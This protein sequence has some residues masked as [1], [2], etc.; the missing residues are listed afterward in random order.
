MRAARSIG[1]SL[2]LIFAGAALADTVTLTAVADNTL[3]ED[4][5]GALSNGSGQHVFA[6]T[7]ASHMIRRACVRFDVSSIPPGSTINSA[8]LTLHLS[9]SI[10]GDLPVNVHRATSAWGE[11]VSIAPGREGMGAPSEPGDA[12]WLHTFYS[13]AFWN[14][15]GGDFLPAV[16]ATRLVG[17]EEAFLDW[18]G[19]GLVADVQ[20]WVD[21][22]AANNGWVLLGEES[23]K[24]SAK[25]FDSRHNIEP[26]FSPMLAIDFTPPPPTC[27]G[28]YDGDLDADFA[29][30]TFVLANFN[31]PY[32]FNDITI[33]LANFGN[34]C[35]P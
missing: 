24:A 32:T 4:A 5:A 14:T 2:A 15:V 21:Q 12:T 30:I 19:S 31:D 3:Y 33:V 18:T 6:G 25:R 11:G 7:N 27:D 10:S 29:D 26:T 22:S 9:R 1:S 13:K 35:S 34:D 28:D 17:F 23:S 8:T 16:S 20:A